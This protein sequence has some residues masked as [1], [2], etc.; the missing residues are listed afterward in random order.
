MKN[1]YAGLSFFITKVVW[2]SHG[3]YYQGLVS[4][5]C[6]SFFLVIFDYF[7]QFGSRPIDLCFDSVDRNMQFCGYFV[8]S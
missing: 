2:N 5:C 3:F 6:V 8:V 4:F 1:F 7:P